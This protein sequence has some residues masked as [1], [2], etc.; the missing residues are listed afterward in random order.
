MSERE[1]LAAR[2]VRFCM[3]T[4]TGAGNGGGRRG[5]RE[6]K[7]LFGFGPIGWV[8]LVPTLA[9]V[10]VLGT[11]H[12]L[13]YQLQVMIHEWWGWD[14]SLFFV[15]NVIAAHGWAS[16]FWPYPPMPQFGLLSLCIVLVGLQIHPRRIGRLRMAAVVLCGLAVP[17]IVF[18]L[19]Q[20]HPFF[21]VWDDDARFAISR[22]ITGTLVATVLWLATRSGWVGV[23]CGAVMLVPAAVDWLCYLIQAGELPAS[24]DAPVQWARLWMG[25][26]FNLALGAVLWTWGIRGRL[27]IRAAHCCQSCGYDLRGLGSGVCPEC[28]SGAADGGSEGDSTGR[29]A[30][31]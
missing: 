2:S 8:L 16:W 3:G 23:L 19:H 13:R 9:L 25:V 26:P 28:G 18:R 17:M 31:A 27:G 7:P 21:V 20:R 1:L 10:L 30:R 11:G 24:L 15:L 6:A 29:G 4:T 5:R 14:G 22:L 12:D